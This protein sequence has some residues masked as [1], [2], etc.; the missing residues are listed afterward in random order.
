MGH[1]V[2]SL[3]DMSTS[4]SV[5]SVVSRWHELAAARDA[6]ALDAVIA[7]GAVFHSPAIHTPQEGRPT[8]IR[9]LAAALD[10]LGPSLTY[11]REWYAETSAV[12]EFTAELDG[13]HVNG[14]DMFE[15]DADGRITDF[16]VMVRPFKGLTKLMELMA[17]RLA[18]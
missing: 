6:T 13:I 9:Y 16:Q 3:R 8:T 15:W 18:Q 11:R 4:P 10:V 12:L 14:V 7:E 17:A 2:R 1:T 5:P